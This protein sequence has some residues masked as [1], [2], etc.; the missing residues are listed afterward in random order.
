M[1]TIAGMIMS[2][3]YKKNKSNKYLPKISHHRMYESKVQTPR[4]YSANFFTVTI[5]ERLHPLSYVET[6]TTNF[7]KNRDIEEKIGIMY[8]AA[9]KDGFNITLRETIYDSMTEKEKRTVNIS[10]GDI[11]IETFILWR[12]TQDALRKFLASH[13]HPLTKILLKIEELGK[14]LPYKCRLDVH[15]E[16]FMLRGKQIVLTDPLYKI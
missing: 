13:N 7:W 1:G 14:S 11:G 9:A 10:L 8:A 4:G 15:S 12:K 16:N 2:N 6:T 5:M 3:S